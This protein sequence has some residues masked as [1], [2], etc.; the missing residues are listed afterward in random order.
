MFTIAYQE[1]SHKIKKIKE[2]AYIQD[3]IRNKWLLL[4]PEEW[5]RQNFIHY[6]INEKQYPKTS[7]AVEKEIITHETKSRFD[8]VVY[9]KLN[10]TSIIIECKN[11]KVKLTPKILQQILNYQSVVQCKYLI[12]TNG[13]FVVG[14]HLQ[15][16]IQELN[17]IPDY[18][19]L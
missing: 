18:N 14:W 9:N 5:V 8:I 2:L 19:D 15:S 6:L 13:D 10:K 3:I 16:S 17:E 11:Q 4:T 1:Y 12:L 7:I